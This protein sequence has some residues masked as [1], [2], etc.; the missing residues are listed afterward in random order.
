MLEALPSRITPLS[1][2]C[3][4]FPPAILTL[5]LNVETPATSKIPVLTFAVFI[6]IPLP[7]SNDVAVK[8]PVTTAPVSAV[9]NFFESL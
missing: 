3:K 1:S 8:I 7:S 6:P 5:S 9:S 2:N 4:S